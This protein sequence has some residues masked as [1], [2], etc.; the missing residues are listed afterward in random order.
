MLLEH[1]PPDSPLWRE[2]LFGAIALVGSF[3]SD[4]EAAAFANDCPYA[5]SASVFS[6]SQA[7]AN[8]LANEL[9]V[10]VVTINEVIVSTA[11]PRLSF[12]GRRRSGFGA[13]RGAEGLLEL[14]SAKAITR[15]RGRKRRAYQPVSASDFGWLLRFLRLAHGIGLRQRLGHTRENDQNHEN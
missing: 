10:G 13:T 5:L 2:D 14:T 4:A 12:G 11:D 1:V 9:S 3:A 8:R 15:T 7:R 6:R